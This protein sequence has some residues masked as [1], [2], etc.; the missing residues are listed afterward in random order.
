MN[1]KKWSFSYK[2]TEKQEW[3][4]NILDTISLWGA[5][6]LLWYSFSSII[7]EHFSEYLPIDWKI[8]GLFVFVLWLGYEWPK[9][10]LKKYTIP[11][12][13]ATIVIPVVYVVFHWEKL[14]DGF[15]GLAGIY[16]PYFNSYYNSNY[17]LGF[18][19]DK[20]NATIA[21]TV[22]S[23]LF[24]W[25]AWTLAY[26]WKKR[27]LL[28][29]FP[30]LALVL[31]LVVGLSPLGN[32][33][34]LAFFGAM[35]LMTVGNSSV[36]QK[37]VT[38]VCVSIAIF[39]S[40]VLFE[41]E[42]RDEVLLKQK[43]ELLEWQNSINL[44]NINLANLF[45]FD[46]HF[47]LEQ[48]DNRTPQYSGKIILEI[49]SS[50]QPTSTV[51]VKG[52][53]G[54]TYDNGN[55]NYDD[56]FFREAC[57]KYGKS[58]EEVAQKIFQMPYI[59]YEE[60]SDLI[61]SSHSLSQDIEYKI[62]YT[63]A[64]GDVAYVP[65]V[66]DYTSLDETY[67]LMGDYLFKKN[68]WDGE[69]TCIGQNISYELGSWIYVNSYVEKTEEIEFIN[70]LSEGYLHVPENAIPFLEKASREIEDEMTLSGIL[71]GNNGANYAEN[72]KYRRI[73]YGQKVAFYLAEQMKY[74][75]KLDELPFGKDPID[76]ALNESHEGYCMHFAS[77]A[78]LLLRQGGVPA[79]YVSGYAVDSSVFVKDE[80]TGVY[81]AAVG[82]YMAHAW[83]EVY[84]N[85]IGWVP[86]EATPGSSLDNLPTQGEIDYW[87]RLSEEN[88]NEHSG[89]EQ[90]SESEETEE[91]EETEDTEDSKNT[92]NSEDTEEMENSQ[93][94]QENP[95]NSQ[96]QTPTESEENDT[97]NQNGPGI[98]IGKGPLGEVLKILGIVGAIVAAVSMV[99]IGAGSVIKRYTSVLQDEI[100]KKMTRKA[101]K[102]INRRMYRKLRICNP[103]LW[104]SGK[105]SDKAYEAALIVQYPQ[106][107]E[108]MWRRFMDIVKKNHYSREEITIEEMQY[109]FECYTKSK[110][111]K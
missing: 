1:V 109:C 91:T 57:R 96:Q 46:F 72:E 4:Q 94:E 68:I 81:K 43:Q 82:D 83:V 52:F 64:T 48:L 22:I 103:K 65:Y 89:Q 26:G 87:E 28:V 33:L 44:E 13:I 37:I 80:A 105:M 77:A 23:M 31:E 62:I 99:V 84:L 8:T 27:V 63:G 90:P 110:E 3:K 35:L 19:S 71:E 59:R 34:F 51:Y 61:L 111:K 36:I 86:L 74:S 69:I 108:D 66:S 42:M 95:Q 55:W 76:Y 17:Y 88:R 73:R 32:G 67:T 45:Q 30:L 101:V 39:L 5:M 11:C 70:G 79:R 97:N 7:G 9:I 38:V 15:L 107:S 100:E 104:F 40:G 92:E 18:A 58:P 41:E 10:Y 75:L 93:S 12:H 29:I 98:G 24:W 6:G 14:L 50:K 47:N 102:R 49:E 60:Y 53:Y 2:R 56:T 106:V 21:F 25:L 20:A 54:T 78:T 16:L 85:N